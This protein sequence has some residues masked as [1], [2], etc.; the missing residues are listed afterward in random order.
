MSSGIFNDRIFFAEC[1]KE[2]ILKINQYI[3][4][5]LVESVGLQRGVT[6]LFIPCIFFYLFFCLFATFSAV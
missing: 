1:A 5:S 3:D 6:L 4:K 2:R